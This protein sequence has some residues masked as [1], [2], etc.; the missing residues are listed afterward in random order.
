MFGFKILEN[1]NYPYISSSIT[2]FWRRWHLSLSRWFRDYLYIPLGGNR[3]APGRTYFNLVVVFFLC[4]LWHGAS[5]NF[6]VWGLFH[7][8]LLVVERAGLSRVLVAAPRL[9]RHLYTL[10]AV[11]IGWTLFRANSMVQAGHFLA[12]MAGHAGHSSAGSL[13][14]IAYLDLDVVIALVAAAIG[15]M[16]VIPVVTKYLADLRASSTRFAQ[17]IALLGSLS[18]NAVL[19]LM[20]FASVLQIAAGTYN[21]FIYFR[22]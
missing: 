9:V 22:F 3:V 16:P 5:W 1:F 10:L 12:A 17:G 15:S 19:L 8:V 11:L 18:G 14:W 2:E 4:G 20:M 21:P 13:P 6:I 7:G